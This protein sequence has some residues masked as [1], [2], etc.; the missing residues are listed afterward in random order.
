MRLIRRRSI[1]RKRLTTQLWPLVEQRTPLNAEERTRGNCS[2][3][4]A[5]LVSLLVCV[6][7]L[8]LRLPVIGRQQDMASPPTT[9]I[10]TDPLNT[11]SPIVARQNVTQFTLTRRKQHLQM[12]DNTT[13]DGHVLARTSTQQ[14]VTV[15][16]REKEKTNDVI[17]SERTRTQLYHRQ[18]RQ[19][20]VANKALR[21]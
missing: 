12:K 16:S 11:T 2:F 10:S 20:D 13:S 6:C 5:P 1:A 8:V 14:T 4:M 9:D 15:N 3:K 19:L 18:T 21:Q 7:Y 17:P